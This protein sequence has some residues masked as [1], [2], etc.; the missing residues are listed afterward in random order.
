MKTAIFKLGLCFLLKVDF[1]DETNNSYSVSLVVRT[2]PFIGREHR[3]ESCTESNKMM[4]CLS[5]PME[6]SAKQ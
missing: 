6:L 2:L 4:L 3:F 5:G 1:A